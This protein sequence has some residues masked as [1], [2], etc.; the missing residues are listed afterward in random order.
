VLEQLVLIGVVKKN[1]DGHRLVNAIV[2]NSRI[3]SVKSLLFLG[4]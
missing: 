2:D 4:N 1:S 3:T